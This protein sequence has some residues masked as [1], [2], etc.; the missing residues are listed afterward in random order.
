METH[1]SFQKTKL[2][3]M[4][5]GYVNIHSVD[6][7]GHSGGIW[8][9]KQ[10]GIN[11]AADIFEVY[12]D[13]I[14][15]RLSLGNAIWFMTGIYAS[16]VY[17][18]RLELWNH[19]TE[20]RKDI[21]EPW[22]LIGD[23]N[24]II[25]PSEQKGGTF[26]HSRAKA[27]SDVMDNC[28]LVDV[29]TTGGTF[30]WSRPC[31]GNRMV[32]RKLDRA[33]ADV[34]WCL[35]FPEAYVEVLCKFHSDHN[36]LLLRCGIPRRGFGP[37]NFRFEAAWISH[38]DY[39]DI[40][41]TAWGK[42]ESDIVTCLQQ[43]QQDSIIFNK[44]CFG[45]IRKNKVQLERRLKGVQNALERV[46]SARLVYLE[47]DLQ[48]EY[49][50]I[51][52]QEE[53]HWYQKA[54]ED[55]IKLGDRNTKFFHTKTIIRR[56]RN[57]IHG[58]HLPNGIW[59]T[60]D[61]MLREAAQD[62]FK[63]LFCTVNASIVIGTNDRLQG[64]LLD[65]E[66]CHSL[67]RQITQEEVT[68]ALN[69]MHPFKA[70]GP[71]GFQ[72]IFFKQYWHIIGDDV[73]R[74]ISTAFETGGFPP[75]LSE[76]LI[77]L[78]PKTD[79]PTNFKEFRPISLCNTVYKLITKIL[80]NR[81]RP[82]LNQIVGPFQ[83]S[84]LP[85]R[86][87]TDNAIILQEAIHS[88]RKSKRKKGDMVFKIDL[89]KAYDNVSWDF[90]QSC[91]VRN[92]FPPATIK[93]IMYCVTSSS[94]TILWNGRRLPSFSPT[95]GLRQGDPLSPYL[96]VLCM[97]F[98]SHYI[99]RNIDDGL[100][101]PVR[102]SRN[103]PPLSHLFFADD[104]LLFAKATKSQ[105]LTIDSTLK[106]FADLSGLKVN[107]SKSKVFFS[108][109][110]RRGK[111]SSIVTST[112]I[113]RTLSLEKYL[114][115]PMMHG[116][117]QRR[118]FAFLEEKISRSLASWKNKLLNKAGRLT[119]VKSVLNSIPNYYMQVAWLP[120]TTCDFID[121]TTRNFLWKGSSNKGIHLVGWDKITKPKK[122]GGL[123]IRKAR[124]A[125]TSLLGKLVWNI[126]KN[127]EALWVQTI[128]HKYLKDD[129]LLNIAKKPGSVT[130]NA[131]FKALSAL[132]EGY[133]FRLGNGN[134]S[135]WFTDWSGSG[136]LANH[137]LYVDI[138]DLEMR[139]RDV[140]I[141]DNW[142]FSLLYTNLPVEMKDMLNSLTINLNSSVNDCH[143][144]KGSLN[145]TY[146]A[147]D[148]YYWL[149]RNSFTA[150]TTNTGSWSWIWQTPAPEKIKFFLWTVVHNSLPTCDMLTHRGILQS[151]LCPRCNN[152]VE[153]T[154]HCLRDCD[155][156]QSIWKSI[157]F[158]DQHFFHGDTPYT[159][160]RFGLG[161][162]TVFLFLAAVWWIWRARNSICID[163]EMVPLYTLKLR[164]TE[165]AH[166]LQNCFLQHHK[167]SAPKLVRW[168]ALGGTGMI[169]NVDGSSIG[170]PG[171]SGYGGTIRNADGAWIHGFFGN[172]GVSNILHA[173]L[174]AIFKGLQLAWELNI[175][176]LWC[177]S[178]SVT[179]LKLISEPV[180]EWHHYAAIIRNI[181]EILN[182]NWHVVILHTY[183]EGNACADF[184][185]KH[186]AR[187]NRGFTSIAIPPAGLNLCL[188]ADASGVYFS[189]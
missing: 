112:G 170:N 80:V 45:N 163:N 140:Y 97:E 84:F 29:N 148:G 145:G 30:T 6:A 20:L 117:L 53:I 189:R 14:T 157:G 188:L 65:E 63:K 108:S 91:L 87:T 89:E 96:F 56:K 74:L 23:F 76:T 132:K 150:D 7:R 159:W 3:W 166:L 177:Y 11:I 36:P 102:L 104:V 47:R 15:I 152:H 171:I 128:K 138:H 187:N 88:M 55:W 167:E 133:Q 83:S 46:D 180:D 50:L 24:D 181:K 146:T 69:Q 54:R 168:N 85:G 90:L 93:L 164:I 25:R 131:I 79:N 123:G 114:G 116:R 143:T 105:A 182:R 66:A 68:Q 160:L 153:T 185:A 174:M 149:N 122:L 39:S 129:V 173:E 175:R 72:G 78:I 106:R 113:N 144:W 31:T 110:T 33:V 98:L 67:T 61:D 43:V 127:N 13:T 42:H 12:K 142:N 9:F 184:L 115:F 147:R 111:I 5:S 34:P 44:E 103:G 141:D 2:F 59:C 125:N 71:D 107:A 18:S 19:L 10:Q 120:Q 38:P 136:I 156:N 169:L 139:V 75:S 81:L 32:S 158:S 172:L 109:N 134:S 101:K 62:Y 124:E 178:D 99:I 58:L 22:L 40:V 60:D 1:V 92:G 28:N 100:W 49:D 162:S 135:F 154:L 64:P 119:L 4:K 52:R 21:V 26:S 161:C 16:P 165:Y 27:M 155:F 86:G 179:A 41:K 70:P 82:F 73:V 121:R 151:N 17:T 95:R 118:D 48:R 51:L 176:N 35:A 37:R 126:H 57:K 186:G 183:R 77:A 94:L 8:L 130:W 137:V